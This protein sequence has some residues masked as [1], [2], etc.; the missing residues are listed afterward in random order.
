VDHR[1]DEHVRHQVSPD[2]ADAEHHERERRHHQHRVT[3]HDVAIRVLV[4]DLAA[5]NAEADPERNAV[6]HDDE[7][8]LERAELRLDEHRARHVT[9]HVAEDGRAV[10]ADDGERHS[11]P[12]PQRIAQSE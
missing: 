1:R 11:D 9:A 12:D 5:Q 10:A 8:H 4:R 6:H 3:P 2:D 7:E